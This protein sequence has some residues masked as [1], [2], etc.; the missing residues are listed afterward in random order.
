MRRK[1]Q[2]RYDDTEW[3]WKREREKERPHWW[4]CQWSTD[5]SLIQGLQASPEAEYQ[6]LSHVWLFVTPRTVAH[7]VP[8]SRRF[9]R[10]EYWSGQLFPSPGDLPGPVIKPRSP[11]LQGDSLP[12]ESP[13]KSQEARKCKKTDSFLEPPE[14]TQ[15][16]YSVLDF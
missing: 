2:Q 1:R 8:L 10:Q 11:A 15:P 4:L 12:S 13:G 5:G 9:F 7:Y 14:R 16:G 6:S 3:G